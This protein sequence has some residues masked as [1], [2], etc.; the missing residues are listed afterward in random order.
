MSD[1]KVT[2]DALRDGLSA[3]R[4]QKGAGYGGILATAVAAAANATTGEARTRTPEVLSPFPVIPKLV[5]C[6]RVPD[7]FLSRSYLLRAVLASRRAYVDSVPPHPS[8]AASPRR[9][10]SR[11]PYCLQDAAT[12]LRSIPMGEDTPTVFVGLDDGTTGVGM[13]SI[14]PLQVWDLAAG[15]LVRKFEGKGHGCFSMINL[16][17]ARIAAGWHTL[18]QYVVAVFDA[19]TGNQLQELQGFGGSILG[20]ARSRITC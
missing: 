20:L 9:P 11:P 10:S 7:R 17:G 8:P 5:R 19:A 3:E 15:K 12:G 18:S 1:A 6:C 13:K 2:K 4:E 14:S 16:P